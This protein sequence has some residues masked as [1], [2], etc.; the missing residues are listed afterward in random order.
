[1]SSS[2]DAT[3]L[4]FVYGALRPSASEDS[5]TNGSNFVGRGEVRG[6]LFVV[7]DAPALRLTP[8]NGRVVGD[9]IRMT[10]EQ[11]R[12]LDESGDDGFRRVKTRI[13]LRDHNHEEVSGWVHEWQGCL[14]GKPR[15]PSGDWILHTFGKPVASFTRLTL[16]PLLGFL[17]AAGLSASDFGRQATGVIW[18]GL[19]VIFLLGMTLFGFACAFVAEKRHEPM[20][21]LRLGTSVV[22]FFLLV[23]YLSTLING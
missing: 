2:R 18:N 21:S 1:M 13:V 6:E 17:V 11:I 12:L 9:V 3:Q 5:R 20:R 19:M 16:L 8:G 7:S 4:V 23:L 22:S 14:E 10:A 15:I